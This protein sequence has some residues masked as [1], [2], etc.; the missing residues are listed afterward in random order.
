MSPTEHGTDWPPSISQESV[1]ST[2]QILPGSSTHLFSGGLPKI[3]TV[4]GRDSTLIWG[5]F[6]FSF[7]WWQLS[8]QHETKHFLLFKWWFKKKKKRGWWSHLC[9][10]VWVGMS[11]RASHVPGCV[12]SSRD[13]D[14][15]IR[16]LAWVW[17]WGW[18]AVCVSMASG[19]LHM[20][21]FASENGTAGV[22]FS[23]WPLEAPPCRD[24]ICNRCLL[25]KLH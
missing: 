20:G 4:L 13:G 17:P 10:S 6:S 21:T 8:W 25:L 14:E 12:M 23:S 2:Q 11:G 18:T 5:T 1:S 19:F 22:L 3:L 15:L 16:L 24:A 7:P 9:S